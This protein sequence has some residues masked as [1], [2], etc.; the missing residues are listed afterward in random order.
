MT[1]SVTMLGTRTT[2][3]L[4]TA[5]LTVAEGCLPVPPLPPRPP[6]SSETNTRCSHA[7]ACRGQ[8]REAERRHAQGGG[9]QSVGTE[10]PE[11]VWSCGD[12]T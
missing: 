7:A 8:G 10:S 11:A 5:A 1:F 4:L 12:V 3:P 6:C 9:V 2:P